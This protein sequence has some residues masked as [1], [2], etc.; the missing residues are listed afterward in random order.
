[1]CSTCGQTCS[2]TCNKP[3]PDCSAGFELGYL[4]GSCSKI[5]FKDNGKVKILDLK[6]GVHCAETQTFLR[7]N[8]DK[9][10]IQYLNE[11]YMSSN[12]QDPAADTQSIYIKDIAG[13]IDL[14][15]LNNV[16]NDT[17]QNCDLL[18]WHPSACAPDGS[19]TDGSWGP[20]TIPYDS[21]CVIE[22]DDEGKFKVL[23]T[24]DN[25]CIEACNL[26]PA[27]KVYMYEFR[28]SWP[29]SHDW[30]FHYGNFNETIPL[31]LS[32]NVPEIFGKMD[33]EVTVEY[34]FMTERPDAGFEASVKSIVL[35]Y[36]D[37]NT[38][39]LHGDLTPFKHD[40]ISL[41]VVNTYPWG[42]R[43]EQ[44]SRTIMVP[45]GSELSL[46]H[47]VRM[48]AVSTSYPSGGL[49]TDWHD[50]FPTAYDGKIADQSGVDN[51]LTNFSRLHAMKVIVR[52]VIA[53]A[54]LALR[55]PSGDGDRTADI[56]DPFV[57]GDIVP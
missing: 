57:P 17:P 45:K 18:V 46:F 19:S 41:E 47:M 39:D 36:L 28:D 21:N 30:P 4:E 38:P 5:Y 16:D 1:M 13:C 50:P 12:G 25:G 2:S 6:E 26:I 29:D 3:K 8:K 42:T 27:N 37:A 53:V 32:D 22:P 44:V 54:G 10:A 9:C 23:T 35:P 24:N 34:S 14:E 43:S 31:Y 15:D 48:R 51:G 52:P 33:L 20:Y 40:A 11:L 55:S 7:L 49:G 56:F